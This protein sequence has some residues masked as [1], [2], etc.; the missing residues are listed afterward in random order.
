LI[1]LDRDDTIVAVPKQIRYLYGD[2]AIEL[3]PGVVEFIGFW[4]KKEIPVAVVS[5]QQGVSN[6]DFPMMTSESV[7]KFNTRLNA[8]LSK[9]GAHIDDFFVCPHLVK[10]GCECRKPKP[11]LIT[12]A[13]ERFS[14][15]PDRTW[16]IGDKMSDVVAGLCAHTNAV[17]FNR[18][19]SETD[20][21][22][23]ARSFE[24][25]LKIILHQSDR[26]S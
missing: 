5:N 16:V 4:N 17:L 19:L 7:L 25:C 22:I 18:K 9:H 2:M 12:Q 10:D 3:I 23:S 6:P 21:A 20:Y 13:M 14:V 26:D 11:G 1:L 8:F 15:S 24:E